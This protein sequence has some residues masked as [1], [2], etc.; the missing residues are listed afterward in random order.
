MQVT[1]DDCSFKM[2][3]REIG[4][5]LPSK[6]HDTNIRVTGE[7]VRAMAGMSRNGTKASFDREDNPEARRIA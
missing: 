2:L 6:A 5:I 1:V 3:T 7:E 4:L